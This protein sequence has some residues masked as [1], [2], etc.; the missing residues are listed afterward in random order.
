[1]IKIKVGTLTITEARNVDLPQE[2]AAWHQTVRVEP[3]TYD[4]FAYLD[5]SDGGYRIHSLSAAC[6][7][8]TVSSNFRSHMLGSW[9]KSDNNRNGQ[10]ATAHIQ[11]ATYGGPSDSYDTGSVQLC[12]AIVRTERNDGRWRLTWNPSCKP[13]VIQQARHGGGLSI[14]AFEDDR[15][16]VVDGTEMSAD[17]AR[18]LD[19]NFNH[20]PRIDQFSVGEVVSGWSFAQKRSIQVTRLA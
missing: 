7:G 13:V 12:D 2:F 5:W 17:E 19:L 6:D 10:I 16:F 1:V 4:V 9:G 20:G 14:A 3:G 8:V 18:K 15:R 11:L